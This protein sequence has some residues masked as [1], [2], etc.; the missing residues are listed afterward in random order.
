MAADNPI[1]IDVANEAQR[2]LLAA[3]EKSRRDERK[4]AALQREI[5]YLRGPNQDYKDQGTQASLPICQQADA[6]CSS[7]HVHPCEDGPHVERVDAKQLK[8]L[9]IDTAILENRLTATTDARDKLEIRC[10]RLNEKLRAWIAYEKAWHAK[11]KEKK[12]LQ[13]IGHQ[14]S[15]GPDIEQ[16]QIRAVS[17]PATMLVPKKTA[18]QATPMATSLRVPL[19]PREE[20][21]SSPTNFEP[22]KTDLQLEHPEDESKTGVSDSTETSD[23]AGDASAPN[24]RIEAKKESFSIE[25][26]LPRY[27]DD[28]SPILVSSRPVKRKRGRQSSPTNVVLKLRQHGSEGPGTAEKPV[29]IKSDQS[30]SSPLAAVRFRTFDDH[31]SMDLDEVGERNFTPRKRQCTDI[32]QSLLPR[33]GPL[34]PARAQAMPSTVHEEDNGILGGEIDNYFGPHNNLSTLMTLDEESCRRAGEEYAAKLWKEQQEK[35]SRYLQTNA[36]SETELPGHVRKSGKRTRAY[37]HNQKLHERQADSS[38]NLQ[39][40]S[41]AVSKLLQTPKS[42]IFRDQSSTTATGGLPT[43]GTMIRLPPFVGDPLRNSV[44]DKSTLVLRPTDP[45]NRILP[46]T[47]DLTPKRKRSRNDHGAAYMHLLAE[48]GESKAT[49]AAREIKKVLNAAEAEDRLEGLLS[50]PSSDK[51]LLPLETPDVQKTYA[52]KV[53]PSSLAARSDTSKSSKKLN[54]AKL[55]TTASTMNTSSNRNEKPIHQQQLSIKPIS[56]KPTTSTFRSSR[57][58]QKALSPEKGPIRHRPLSTLHRRHFK[59][60]PTHNPGYNYAYRDVIRKHDDRKCL[61]GCTRPNCCG[62]TIRKVLS[63]GGALPSAHSNLFFSS[64]STTHAEDHKLLKEYMGDNYPSWKKMTEEEKK[65]EWMK[66]QEWNFG[67]TFG[68]HKDNGRQATPPGFWRVEMASTQDREEEGREAERME[69]ERVEGM[70]RESMR[71]GGLWVFADE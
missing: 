15:R 6:D 49:P 13:S 9:K 7:A 5:A 11:K 41:K 55:S 4:I 43:P 71:K 54:S 8:Q 19:N 35:S 26:V 23:D 65:E 10:R 59:P 28:S 46:R 63:I 40:S 70:W 31:D 27:G 56:T 47:G 37:L 62:D 66:A 20:H 57:S 50:K 14:Q 34:S 33:V 1:E 48:D 32:E 16:E 52:R 45:N 53:E 68:R 18:P 30:S 64:L 22:H 67:K 17:A 58:P 69:R 3:G 42:A 24:G 39:K 12:T 51:P 38:T 61:P 25:P 36:Q 60:N 44:E 2:A 21:Q 29:P